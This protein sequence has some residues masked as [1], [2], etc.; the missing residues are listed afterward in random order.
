MRVKFN[1]PICIVSPRASGK[2]YLAKY[3]LQVLES[4]FDLLYI[5]ANPAAQTQYRP[6][7][8]DAKYVDQLDSDII[9]SLFAT[10]QKRIK[11]KKKPVRIQLLFDDSLERKN[12][13]SDP[14]TRCFIWGRGHFICP[15]LLAHNPS[16]I[17]TSIRSNT[18]YFV[19]FQVRSAQAR[20]YL[21]DNIL[22][23][24]LDKKE[25]AWQ[26][27]NSLEQ[28]ECLIADWANGQNKLYRFKAP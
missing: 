22:S 14:L 13:Y 10:N 23:T 28:Y 5:F 6:L 25:K 7:F 12:R 20:T 4:Q 27:L 17:N 2:T 19:T 18:D 8:P 21:Y 16:D 24:H 26:L 11:R 3:L 15:I 1:H 9:D